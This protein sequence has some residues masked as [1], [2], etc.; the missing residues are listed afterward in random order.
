MSANRITEQEPDEYAARQ[1]ASL[2]GIAVSLVLIVFGLALV[3]GLHA[4]AVMQDC[5]LAGRPDCA[6]IGAP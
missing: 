2:A 6:V 5:L 4:R 1:T 3:R